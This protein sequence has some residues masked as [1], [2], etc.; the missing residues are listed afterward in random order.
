MS[1]HPASRASDL[2]VFG[3]LMALTAITVGVA[4]VD[5][6]VLNPVAALTIAVVKALLVLVFF[7]HLR[8][9]SRVTWLVA[10]AGLF[11]LLILFGL[12]MGD[13]ATRVPITL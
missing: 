5:L 12:L 9:S 4:T 7:M 3:A 1:E 6:G 2:A 10:G 13:Y 8:Y 11:W